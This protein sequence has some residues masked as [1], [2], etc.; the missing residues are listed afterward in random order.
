MRLP[1]VVGLLIS[2]CTTT[3]NGPE[4]W[5]FTVAQ[6]NFIR[7]EVV[8]EPNGMVHCNRFKGFKARKTGRPDVWQVSY[9]E[10]RE[11]GPWKK[12]SATIRREGDAWLWQAGDP[13][14]CSITILEG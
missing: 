4:I 3:G 11:T 1:L 10:Y 9:K 5:D 14:K 13:P 12:L 8:G 6:A 7:D 2:G